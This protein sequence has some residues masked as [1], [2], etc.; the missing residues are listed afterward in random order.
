VSAIRTAIITFLTACE[1]S[2][3]IL[4]LRRQVTGHPVYCICYS[5]LICSA[6][7]AHWICNGVHYIK[8]VLLTTYNPETSL[9]P[10]EQAIETVWDSFLHSLRYCDPGD[11]CSVGHIA[12]IEFAA[13]CSLFVWANI[14][15]WLFTHFFILWCPLF[16]SDSFWTFILSCTVYRTN[17]QSHW[18]HCFSKSCDLVVGYQRFERLTR[19]R[20]ERP[21]WCHLFYYYFI[22]CSTCFGR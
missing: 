18:M 21:T 6:R 17:Y 2:N 12:N 10:G 16:S 13:H 15:W 19:L 3:V 11:F 14:T 7:S 20:K 8:Q 1:A 5:T 22:Q 4:K 9:T